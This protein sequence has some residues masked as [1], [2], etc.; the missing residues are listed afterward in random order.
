MTSF[1]AACSAASNS[2]YTLET[3]Q[4]ELN[5]DLP[6]GTDSQV[7]EKYLID[8]GFEHSGI[9]DNAG[10]THM[11]ADPETLELRSIIRETRK[12]MLVTTD[13][14]MI[15]TFGRDHK[16]RNISVKESHTGL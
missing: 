16:L 8:K 7:I 10:S 15:F 5:R 1:L 3:I 4:S 14:A 12:N 9:I 2:K 11:G 13:I 6:K